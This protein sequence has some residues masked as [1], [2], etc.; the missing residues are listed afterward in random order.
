MSTPLLQTGLGA[1]S[2]IL[3]L[4]SHSSQQLTE[5]CLPYSILWEAF[6]RAMKFPRQGKPFNINDLTL[7]YNTL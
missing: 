2:S 5:L 3:A 4:S 1:H 6:I 7:K